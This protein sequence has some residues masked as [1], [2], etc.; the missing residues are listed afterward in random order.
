VL[1]AALIL[2]SP[3]SFAQRTTPAPP[4]V[5][6]VQ[7]QPDKTKAIGSVPLAEKQTDKAK[8][9]VNPN[10]VMKQQD[11][12]KTAAPHTYLAKQKFKQACAKNCYEKFPTNY[13]GMPAPGQ[14]ACLQKCG[15]SY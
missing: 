7:K 5:P 9:V 11:K 13:F 14:H 6:A 10:T 1:A 15:S 3:E 8:F 4:P 12:A 2:L